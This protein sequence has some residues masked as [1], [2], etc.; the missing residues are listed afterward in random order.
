MQSQRDGRESKHRNLKEIMTRGGLLVL[1]YLFALWLLVMVG[2]KRE[3][4]ELAWF[5]SF[6][7]DTAW[8]RSLLMAER[9]AT[10]RYVRLPCR[11]VCGQWLC[12]AKALAALGLHP[13]GPIPLQFRTYQKRHSLP[14]TIPSTITHTARQP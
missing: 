12:L 5:P 1:A 2:W 7:L 14:T 4:V 6:S 9:A 10:C 11:F 13:P 8:H 3:H